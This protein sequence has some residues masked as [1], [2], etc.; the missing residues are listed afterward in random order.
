MSFISVNTIT[1]Y[2]NLFM[3]TL[4]SAFLLF[5]LSFFLLV[6]TT[7]GFA[8]SAYIITQYYNLPIKL[9]DV[10][11]SMITS[12][13]IKHIEY[14]NILTIS[15]VEISLKPFVE[16]RANI[17]AERLHIDNAMNFIHLSGLKKQLSNLANPPTSIIVQSPSLTDRKA[18]WKLSFHY[19]TNTYNSLFTYY[20]D[21]VKGELYSDH[22]TKC[23]FTLGNNKISAQGSILLLN[24]HE[25]FSV[26]LN[27]QYVEPMKPSMY[28]ALKNN[29]TSLLL[30][31][32]TTSGNYTF[33]GSLVSDNIT[34]KL[35]GSHNQHLMAS[36]QARG[37]IL[38]F[39]KTYLKNWDVQFNVD[40]NAINPIDITL[41]AH[42]F[43]RQD[44][45]IDNVTLH[46]VQKKLGFNTDKYEFNVVS[47]DIFYTDIFLTD[48]IKLRI[49]RDGN[50]AAMS[51]ENTKTH[52]FFSSWDISKQHDRSWLARPKSFSLG[53]DKND[54]IT[55]PATNLIIADD[56][57]SLTSISGDNDFTVGLNAIYTFDDT[58]WSEV[59]LKE[60]PIDYFPFMLLNMLEVYP[61]DFSGY[62]SGSLKT[63]KTKEDKSLIVDGNLNF[64]LDKGVIHNLLPQLPFI[65]DVELTD[66]FIAMQISHNKASLQSKSIANKG[67]LTINGDIDANRPFLSYK[68][69]VLGEG[70]SF[71]QKNNGHITINTDLTYSKEELNID[72]HGNI[73]VSSAN[74]HNQS[75][76]TA[77]RLPSETEVMYTNPSN[78][79]SLTYS[80]DMSVS[81]TDKVYMHALGFHG[82]L[83]GN[84][85]LV[86]TKYD[87]RFITD[88]SLNMSDGILTLYGQQLPLAHCSVNWYQSLFNKPHVDLLLMQSNLITL[89]DNQQYGIRLQGIIDNLQVEFISTSKTMSNLEILTHLLLDKQQYRADY[90]ESI[91]DL[92]TE[93]NYHKF[94]GNDVAKLIDLLATFKQLIFFDKV[95]INNI[96]SEES[97][98]TKEEV[99]VLLTRML[100]DRFALSMRIN[101]SDS[102]KN[103]FGFDALL[104]EKIK[105]RSYFSQN[106]STVNFE[107]YYQ[108]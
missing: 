64:R 62:L 92:L 21:K 90:T 84:V 12:V 53:T 49:N 63:S 19:L 25:P 61:S 52:P 5:L 43:G 6:S 38:T 34:L 71:S 45:E 35:D 41:R 66:T 14:D 2:A 30:E 100:N 95:V 87:Q 102:R 106:P 75:W 101:S 48:Q 24:H 50:H 79:S 91:D 85:H 77:L 56:R 11:G 9:H 65:S 107:I 17:K 51:I 44:V 73:L 108:D 76:Q 89:G 96:S 80:Y 7:T 103:Q 1:N 69:H 39:D 94:A 67:L 59:V 57:I 28:F 78:E 93:L 10:S 33:N 15:D 47:G 13:H 74:Y 98:K 83:V 29:T 26:N 86:K 8:V 105:L 23:S 82:Q 36:L 16:L 18:P 3:R 58:L 104:S 37:K 54:K 46:Y 60:L 31:A 4:M 99:E 97:L 72:T 20:D 88:G 70:L 68:F 40:S 42:H 27:S 81:L 55:F 22:H 32:N